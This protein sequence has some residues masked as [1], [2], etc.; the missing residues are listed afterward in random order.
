[1]LQ[2]DSLAQVDN[3]ALVF[4]LLRVAAAAQK[5][6]LRTVGIEANGN[7]E[8]V[9]GAIMLADHEPGLP[10]PGKGCPEAGIDLDGRVVIFHRKIMLSLLQVDV[11]AQRIVARA[12]PEPYGL[13]HRG[14]RRLVVALPEIERA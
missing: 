11:A 5:I 7:A 8:I 12:R 13:A 10:A 3:G 4:A 14:N 9:N 2:A 1:M 6:R